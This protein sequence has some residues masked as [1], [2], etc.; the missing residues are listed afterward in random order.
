MA[1]RKKVQRVEK[2]KGPAWVVVHQDDV[3]RLKYRAKLGEELKGFHQMQAERLALPA[4]SSHR[5]TAI[6]LEQYLEHTSFLTEG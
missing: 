4:H 2:P 6:P 3:T 1:P 5:W